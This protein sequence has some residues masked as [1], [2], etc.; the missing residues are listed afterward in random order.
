MCPV[1]PP[2][3]E[4]GTVA[5]SGAGIAP[6]PPIAPPLPDAP[7]PPNGLVDSSFTV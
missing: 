7:V 4:I 5:D 1:G 6:A 3:L 2:Q